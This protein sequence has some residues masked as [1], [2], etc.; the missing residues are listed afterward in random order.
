MY[1]FTL[2]ND[3]QGLGAQDHPEAARK[4]AKWFAIW[5]GQIIIVSIIILKKNGGADADSGG[6]C[7][8]Q[9]DL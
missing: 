8:V 3:Y 5:T 1:T 7:H 4:E 9:A 6:E 2:Y